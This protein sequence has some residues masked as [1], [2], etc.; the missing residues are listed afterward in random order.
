VFAPLVLPEALVVALVVLPVGVHV[1]EKV[2]LSGGA[3]D[4]GDV[5]V[6]SAGVAVGVVGAVAVIGP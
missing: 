3:K 1:A 2:S 4:G 5:G 6:G